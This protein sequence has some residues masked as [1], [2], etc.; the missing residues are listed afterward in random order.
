MVFISPGV[1]LC[2]WDCGAP[3]ATPDRLQ[4]DAIA[5]PMPCQMPLEPSRDAVLELAPAPLPPPGPKG[6]WQV[7]WSQATAIRQ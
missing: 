2:L 1:S 6:G 7:V 5:G 3:D 4:V